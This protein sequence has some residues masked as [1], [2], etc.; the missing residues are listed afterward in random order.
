M[1]VFEACWE[2]ILRREAVVWQHDD[3]TFFCEWQAPIDEVVRAPSYEG[4]TV[5]V[6]DQEE[7][8]VR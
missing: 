5:A 7:A 3:C 1:T 4:S 2:R 6:T 8:L